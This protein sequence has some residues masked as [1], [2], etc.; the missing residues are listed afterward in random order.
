MQ[1]FFLFVEC[2]RAELSKSNYGDAVLNVPAAHLHIRWGPGH[3]YFWLMC[4]FDG[5]GGRVI[6]CICETTTTQNGIRHLRTRPQTENTYKCAGGGKGWGARGEMR[7]MRGSKWFLI[8]ALHPLF[9]YL[10]ARLIIPTYHDSKVESR[11][12]IHETNTKWEPRIANGLGSVV[13][14]WLVLRV[15]H[16]WRREWAL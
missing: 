13:M 6:G 12:R 8:D 5:A 10:Q 16:R 7:W 15:E 4:F 2:A 1:F 3:S 11:C 9:H 14:G